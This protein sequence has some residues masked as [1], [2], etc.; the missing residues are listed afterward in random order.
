MLS[1]HLILCQLL[2]LPALNLSHLIGFF[3]S[4]SALQVRW[5]T[6]WS[7]TFGGSN[8]SGYSVL[9]SFR[10]DWF[11]LIAVQ[12]TLKN[13]LQHHSSKAPIL[14]HS[15]F[16]MVQ[17]SYPYMTT[18]KTI[19]LTIWTFVSRVMSLLF[20]MLSRFVIAFFPRNKHLLISW[21]QSLSA[22]I[23]EPKKKIC[24]CFHFP[25]FYLLWSDGTGCHTFSFLNVEF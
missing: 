25:P 12:G 13:F 18:R 8:S 19:A 23:L 22:V 2:S 6:N 14:R 3:S 24:H 7:F 10:I 4:E 17:L 5:P 20:N 15:V 21:L 11:D 9:I 1:N 16:F